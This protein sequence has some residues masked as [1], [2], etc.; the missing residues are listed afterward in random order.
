MTSPTNLAPIVTASRMSNPCRRE[1]SIVHARENYKELLT[2]KLM[3]FAKEAMPIGYLGE[4][5][6]AK[7]GPFIA[8]NLVEGMFKMKEAIKDVT[9][10][11]L[12]GTFTIT[13]KKIKFYKSMC[14][15]VLYL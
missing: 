9:S 11:F 1:I 14:V 7:V 8:P 6:H 4:I 3:P 5:Q 10:V 13:T 12:H 15:K 2:W